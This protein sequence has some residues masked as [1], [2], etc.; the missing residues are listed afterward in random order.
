MPRGSNPAASLRPGKIRRAGLFHSFNALS[1]ALAGVVLT[2]SAA[3]PS[4]EPLFQ[5]IRTGNIAEIKRALDRG[6]SASAIDSNG[7][8]ALMLATLFGDAAVVK[9]LLDRSAD[10]NAT[11][12]AGATALM[13]AMPEFAES[14]LAHCTRSECKRTICRPRSNTPA[15]GC[16][17]SKHGGYF[18]SF[19]ETGSRYQGEGQGRHA[20]SR[21]SSVKR[22]R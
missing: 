18:A 12:E 1:L 6:I 22:R 2:I 8:P 10:P 15:G 11:N 14:E 9:L 3:T 4:P 13:W 16:G 5:A 21:Q 17:I 20:R 7:T 19:G